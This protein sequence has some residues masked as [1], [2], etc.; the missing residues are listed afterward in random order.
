M[1]FIS[2]LGLSIAAL[3][4][5]ICPVRTA[6]QDE[7]LVPFETVV[8]YF[9]NGPREKLQMVVFKNR[10][11]KQL[12]N[13]AHA[14]FVSVPPRPA[15]DFSQRMIIAVSVEYL[16]DPSWSLA[17]S[18]VVKTENGLK[19]FIRETHRGGRFCPPVPDILVHPLQ[20]IEADRVDKHVIKNAEFEV[21]QQVVECEPPK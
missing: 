1:L 14:G 2:K 12:W 10:D 7:Q 9:T 19:I 16:P 8:K 3:L 11:W 4:L 17:I 15:V 18:R 21:E 6:T 13:R 5:L 20:V